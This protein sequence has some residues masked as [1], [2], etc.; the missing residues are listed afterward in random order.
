MNGAVD[1]DDAPRLRATQHAAFPE[2]DGFDLGVVYHHEFDNL[3]VRADLPRRVGDGGARSRQFCQR[4][5][6][7][8]IHHEIKP[9]RGDVNRH[10]LTD[11]AQ[12]NKP[13]PRCHAY[14]SFG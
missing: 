5:L 1:G 4:L 9:G 7:H 2:G 6:P 10:R 13:D 12:T 3:P 11:V 8:V 14:P